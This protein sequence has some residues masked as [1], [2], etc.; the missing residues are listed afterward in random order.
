MSNSDSNY[1]LANTTTNSIDTRL[2]KRIIAPKIFTNFSKTLSNAD[3][4]DKLMIPI[5]RLA[6]EKSNKSEL[7]QLMIAYRYARAAHE[8][9]YR[10]SGDPYI[11]HPIAVTHILAEL[12][13]DN[14]TLCAS[15]LH[16]VVED[17]AINNDEITQKFGK[18]IAM[19]VDGVTKLSR[20]EYGENANTETIRKMIVAMSQDIRVIIIKLADRLHNAKT[21]KYVSNESAQK[22]AKETLDIYAPLAHRL[23][24]N[25]IKRELEDLS[26]NTLN[27]KIYSEIEQLVSQYAPQ[28]HEFVQNIIN[29]VQN[30]LEISNIKATVFGRPKHLFSVYQK[31]IIK[32]KDF[33]DIYDLVGVRILTDSILDCYSA[34]GA[35]HSKYNHLPGRF[36]D[37]IAMPK[38][39]MYQ[40]IHTTVIGPNGKNVELQIRTRQMHQFAQFGIA[41]HW[42]YKEN[43]NDKQKA[44][45][46]D[47]NVT[48]DSLNS[49]S[50]ENLQWLKQ[51][52]D[53]QDETKDSSE[54]L[55][56]LRFDLST[57]QVYIFTPKGE[58]L[59][60]PQGATSID[61]AYLI[62]TDI[63]HKTVGAKINGKL[64]PLDTE[65]QNGDRVEIITT[66]NNTG[67]NQ[68][69]LK[70]AKTQK[71][72]NKIKAW[73]SKSRKEA[74][75]EQGR[76]LISKA[77][78]SKS[79][80]IKR[81]I[82]HQILT[83][84]AD[85]LKYR[86]I[87]SLYQAVGAGNLSAHTVI[88]HII[89]MNQDDLADESV[90]EKN[91]TQTSDNNSS[92]NQ[93]KNQRKATGISISG[94]ESNNDVWIKLA[95]CCLPVPGDEIIGFITKDQGI[96]VHRKDCLNISTLIKQGTDENRFIQA[97]WNR[98][99]INTF[100]VQIQIEAIDRY[101]LLSDITKVLGDNHINILSAHVETTKDKVSITKWVFEI[102]DIA[103]LA[104]IMKTIRKVDGVFDVY[105][106]TYRQ[107]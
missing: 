51:L 4:L 76:N 42:K 50:K 38:Y 79:L 31:M 93:S 12:G 21:W 25:Q 32:G 18:N 68:D 19:L 61:F 102:S 17:T 35:I 94:I 57:D 98:D 81:I 87:D 41:A 37:Y 44:S 39:N 82:N 90:D 58:V 24:L 34:L 60:L 11:T 96:S 77:I 95:K 49:Q 45:K 101:S 29:E 28:R 84:I 3:D 27:P 5:I 6:H 43:V 8:G 86:D 89:K 54:F 36:K 9:Q 71:A 85:D 80:P 62:H 59:M 106:L 48:S 7:E 105:R 22:K 2:I 78:R 53:W 15:L 30:I 1:S 63:G 14:E 64:L 16:D 97:K 65:L 99:E 88:S 103:H 13:A 52:V 92:S 75:I 55:E 72:K 69:W 47:K 46:A 56:S 23:G 10:K 91:F 33:K 104:S 40:S 20:L 73:F 107:S 100:M 67:P 66:K 26:F 83:E 70:F 74:D